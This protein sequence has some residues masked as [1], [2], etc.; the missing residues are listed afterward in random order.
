MK[1]LADLRAD[2]ERPASLPTRAVTIC[3]DQ[4]LLA[5]IQRLTLEKNDLLVQAAVESSDEDKPG[6][7]KRQG[8][9]KNPRLAEIDAEI[10]PLYAEMREASG[11]I[12]LRAR[13][14]GEWLR[15]KD[16]HPAREKNESDDRLA[17][18]LC[19]AADLLDN[20]GKYV[21]SWNGDE[22][23]PGEWDGWFKGKVAPA[24]LGALVTAVV[25]MHESRVTAP[26]S[27]STSSELPTSVTDS[28]SPA[29]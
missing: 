3:L 16:E 21:V 29:A 15:W 22:F 23:G 19:N 26:K 11:E 18:G 20:L 1:S 8:E 28:P 6:R 25:E 14:G 17:F 2:K 5:D 9:G 27:P 7:P 10:E 12:L 4:K 24:D 13:P